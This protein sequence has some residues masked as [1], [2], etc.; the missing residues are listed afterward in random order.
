MVTTAV[1][2][3]V[4]ALAV[5]RILDGARGGS[6][7]AAPA[8]AGSAPS[9]PR[10]TP[11]ATGAAAAYPAPSRPTG[12]VT[13]VQDGPGKPCT[14][15]GALVGG[16]PAAT[17]TLWQEPNGLLTGRV[18]PKAPIQVQC[19]ADLQT[20]N[21]VFK[22]G[23]TNTWWVWAQVSPGVWDWLPETAVSEGGPDKP[24]A[25]VALCV[26]APAGEGVQPQA[27]RYAGSATQRS[28]FDSQTRTYRLELSF[29]AGASTV[30]YPELGC[31]G[32]LTPTGW[33]GQARI[34]AEQITDGGCDQGGTWLVLVLDD[35]RVTAVYSPAGGRYL[36]DALL[37]R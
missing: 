20:T 8:G 21:P 22:P 4:A 25:G 36:T 28:L 27:G 6:T 33:R 2:V 10:P 19:Q 7:P 11:T 18:V 16:Y 13:V 5:P 31:R 14:P 23:Q 3:L 34:Y 15:A 9:T 32:T 1:I 24:L 35:T 29:A 37:T 30:S 26:T 17:C 12:A